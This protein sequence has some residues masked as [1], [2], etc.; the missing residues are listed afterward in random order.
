MTG[1]DGRQAV[2]A[3][4]AAYE[5]SKTGKEI[6]DLMEQATDCCEDV[7]DAVENAAV[8]GNEPA[9]VF[10]AQIAFDR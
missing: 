1:W 2:A 9:G 5:S 7:A 8:A 10:Y 4:L 3:A 6:L